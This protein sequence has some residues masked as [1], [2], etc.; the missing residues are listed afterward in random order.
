LLWLSDA[1]LREVRAEIDA[2]VKQRIDNRA[3]R[4]RKPHAL[5]AILFPTTAARAKATR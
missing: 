3:R 4:G 5:T 1:E 2:I